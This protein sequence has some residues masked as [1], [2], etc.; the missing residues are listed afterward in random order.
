MTHPTDGATT[1]RATPGPWTDDEL[2]GL[3]LA[4][5]SDQP[6]GEDAVPL[7]VYLSGLPG[8]LPNWYMPPAMGHRGGRWRGPVIV[9]VV[10]AF[11][12][13]DAFGLC[14]TY[15]QLVFA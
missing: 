12:I 1:A 3:A 4:A 14:S 10:A 8:P 11:L 7:S 5:P 6:L 13:I 15:G 2:A 9:A